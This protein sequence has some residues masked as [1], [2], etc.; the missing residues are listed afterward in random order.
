MTIIGKIYIEDWVNFTISSGRGRP[1]KIGFTAEHKAALHA[2][3]GERAM[4][5]IRKRKDSDGYFLCSICEAPPEK[6]KVK[7]PQ[8]RL[9][10]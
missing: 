1:K 8:K 10:K 6:P 7:N 2:Y 4:V 5:I 9:F 3:N